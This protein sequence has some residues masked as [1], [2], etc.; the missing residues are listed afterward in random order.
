MELHGLSDVG[1]MKNPHGFTCVEQYTETERVA[2]VGVASLA[3]DVGYLPLA[4][5]LPGEVYGVF[6][7]ASK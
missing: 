3:G 2:Y 5:I 4:I 6:A 1:G 7:G